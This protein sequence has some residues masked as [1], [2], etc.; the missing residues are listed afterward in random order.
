MGISPFSEDYPAAR[1]RV[2]RGLPL[3]VALQGFSDAGNVVAQ[4]EGFFAEHHGPETIAVFNNDAFLDYRARRPAI[5]FV[6][7]HLEQ[8]EPARLTLELATDVVGSEFLLLRGYEPDFQWELFLETVLGMVEE[9][10]VSVTTWVHAI[11]MP[12]PHTRPIGTTVSGSR[13]ELIEER[14]IWQPT[15]RLSASV[16]HALEHRLFGAGAEVVGFV[17][18]VPHYLAN[19]EYPHALTTGLESIM[20][21]TGLLFSTVDLAEEEREYL[22]Q[23]NEQVQSNPESV[24]M[25]ANLERR[26]DEYIADQE[27]RE[28]P[29]VDDEGNL[30]TAEQIATQLE[31]YLAEHWGDA[32]GEPSSEPDSEPPG[33]ADDDL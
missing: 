7:D 10:E 20:A 19:T 3:V 4:L 14:S 11:P 21:A 5:S 26:Y 27:R 1:E 18:L 12:V 28:Q 32:T 8:Y 23:V 29:L 6:R 9:F 15:T 13:A 30:P 31:S 17:L 2:R 25:V 22:E 24:E 16:G 33:S